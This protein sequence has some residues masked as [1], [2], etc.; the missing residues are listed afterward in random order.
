MIDRDCSNRGRDNSKELTNQIDHLEKLFRGQISGCY[1]FLPTE[2]M[3]VFFSQWIMMEQGLGNIE[4]LQHV[5]SLGKPVT[6]FFESQKMGNLDD[7]NRLSQ[8][9]LALKVRDH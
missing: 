9:C 3:E 1:G 6:P 5:V 7:R 8:R 4:L 2:E